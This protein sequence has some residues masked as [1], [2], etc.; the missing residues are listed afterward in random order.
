MTKLFVTSVTPDDVGADE[1][2]TSSVV[3]RRELRN[4]FAA[5]TL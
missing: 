2:E 4:F 1:N 5:V 3:L